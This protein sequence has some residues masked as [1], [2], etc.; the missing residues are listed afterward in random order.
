MV[1]QKTPISF[2][3]SVWELFWGISVGASV[4]FLPPGGEKDPSIIAEVIEKHR[5]TVVQFVP[6]MLSV[7]LDHFDHIELKPKCSSVRH[8]FSGGEELSPGLVRRFQ[9]HWDQSEQV[10][11]TN[12][13]GPTEA[14]IYVNAFDCR[15]NQIKLRLRKKVLLYRFLM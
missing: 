8:V 12:F 13:Y 4:S 10:K 3:V 2:D 9:Q 14:T 5:V 15:L 1:L 6:S 7:F 11:L